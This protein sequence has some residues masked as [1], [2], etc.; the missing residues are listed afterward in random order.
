MINELHALIK[1]TKNYRKNNSVSN[2][3]ELDNAIQ[4]AERA[5]QINWDEIHDE[6]LNEMKIDER[7][8]TYAHLQ[9]AFYWFKEMYSDEVSVCECCG[10]EIFLSK[11][12]CEWCGKSWN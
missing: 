10:H 4:D 3:V 11:P 1:A 2:H 5:L 12:K 7:M 9:R 6:F 8:T